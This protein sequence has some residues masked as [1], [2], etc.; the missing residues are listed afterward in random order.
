MSPGSH[1]KSWV[2]ELEKVRCEVDETSKL[3]NWP[4]MFYLEFNERSF[5]LSARTRFELDEWMRV[6]TLI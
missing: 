4:Y 3:S 6:F 2:K 5:T 1:V